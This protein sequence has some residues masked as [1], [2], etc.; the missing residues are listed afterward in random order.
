MQMLLQLLNK[1]IFFTILAPIAYYGYFFT[2]NI[3]IPNFV[4]L[5]ERDILE[6]RQIKNDAML[7]RP[8]IKGGEGKVYRVK[9][10]LA[11]PYRSEVYADY[12]E[13][14]LIQF[15][16][17]IETQ[18]D[19]VLFELKSRHVQLQDMMINYVRTHDYDHIA[20]LEY[21]EK[22][23]SGIIKTIN[24]NI[25]KRGYIDTVYIENMIFN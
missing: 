2:Q 23:L 19:S 25:L 22:S 6:Q 13:E 15:T 10:I 3:I 7:R 12:L 1:L 5:K 8:R 21:D 14:D 4:E 17:S 9:N 11:N 18:D 16:L 24:N 20:M